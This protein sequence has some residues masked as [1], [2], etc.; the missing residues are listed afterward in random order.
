MGALLF[1]GPRPARAASQPAGAVRP[2]PKPPRHCC[3]CCCLGQAGRVAIKIVPCSHLAFY[4]PPHPTLPPFTAGVLP[5]GFRQLCPP[6]GVLGLHVHHRPLGHQL[7]RSAGLHCPDA[8][9]HRR[10]AGARAPHPSRPLLGFRLSWGL[11][12]ARRGGA[13]ACWPGWKRAALPVFP[14]AVSWGTTPAAVSCY[15]MRARPSLH[16][17]DAATLYPPPCCYA[18]PCRPSPCS[19]SSAHQVGPGLALAGPV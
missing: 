4:P 5:R 6:A 8:P 9:S 19:S 11:A 16:P 2:P 3:R 14:P 17:P 12:L 15:R 13:A 18:A 7:V 10:P 1:S